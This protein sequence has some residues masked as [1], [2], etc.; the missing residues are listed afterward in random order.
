MRSSFP[1]ASVSRK[2]SPSQ[3]GSFG[4]DKFVRINVYVAKGTCM[5]RLHHT[6][7]CKNF[8]KKE[9]VL[10][11]LSAHWWWV[12]S[13]VSARTQTGL[14]AEHWGMNATA[15]ANGDVDK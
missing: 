15:A 2:G 9:V 11:I 6:L 14:D 5:H 12:L 10:W 7:L 1:I 4:L 13:I 8:E 3:A